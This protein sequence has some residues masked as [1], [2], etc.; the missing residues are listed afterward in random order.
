MYLNIA[1]LISNFE[2]LD[3]LFEKW[4]HIVLFCMETCVT[5][6]IDDHEISMKGD[7]LIRCDSHSRHYGGVSAHIKKNFKFD[8]IVNK[9]YDQSLWVLNLKINNEGISGRYIQCDLSFAE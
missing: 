8:V 3:V 6:Q 7:K 9:V 5:S 1:S 2:S 4:K